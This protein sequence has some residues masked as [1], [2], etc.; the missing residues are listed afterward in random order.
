MNKELRDKFKE[1]WKREFKGQG[2]RGG[3]SRNMFFRFI[4]ARHDKSY[5]GKDWSCVDWIEKCDNKEL[6]FNDVTGFLMKVWK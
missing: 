5:W 4:Q 3:P 6:A 1:L 2:H